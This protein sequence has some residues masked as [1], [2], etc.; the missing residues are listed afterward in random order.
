MKYIINYI[1]QCFCKHK[2]II[3]EEN[4]TI[5]KLCEKCGYHKIINNEC[6]HDWEYGRQFGFTSQYKICKK[7]NKKK[8]VDMCDF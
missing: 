7:C 3:R 8:I 4:P 5:I 2:F 6:I 1:R